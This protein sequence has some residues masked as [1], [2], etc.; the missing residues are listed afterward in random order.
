MSFDLDLIRTDPVKVTDGVEV[1][2]RRGSKLI[3][4]KYNNPAAENFRMMETLKHSELFSK[5]T[6]GTATQEDMKRVG[7]ITQ[8]IEN[9][10]IA[11]HI[12]K[13]W[14]GITRAKQ[15]LE[16]TSELAL[17]ILSDPEN[18]DFKEDV[19][20]LSRDTGNYR[21]EE[22]AKAKVKKVAASS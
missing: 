17:D 22:K 6:E 18:A 12:L 21:P 1:P 15:P 14:V 13:G 16:F 10:A 9:K 20:N 11:Y 4:A 2:Y 8:E 19:I 5:V 3:L 7:E